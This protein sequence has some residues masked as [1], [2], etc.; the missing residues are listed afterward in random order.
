MTTETQHDVRP[1]FKGWREVH[2][3]CNFMM[4][5]NHKDA[6]G[7][8]KNEVGYAVVKVHKTWDQIGGDKLYDECLKAILSFGIVSNLFNF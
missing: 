5:T 1:L 3:A 4:A 7:L 6:V 8:S 2:S